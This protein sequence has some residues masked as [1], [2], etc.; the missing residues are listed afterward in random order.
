MSLS[1][2]CLKNEN[3][4]EEVAY[5]RLCVPEVVQEFRFIMKAMQNL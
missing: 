1:Q 3:S 4:K 5:E 2:Q